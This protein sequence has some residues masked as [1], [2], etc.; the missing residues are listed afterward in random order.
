L[1][2]RLF[3][4]WNHAYLSS[5]LETL[6]QKHC[7]KDQW[8][9][10]HPCSKPRRGHSN[11]Q[12][13]G[14]SS[15][16]SNHNKASSLLNLRDVTVPSS[17][18]SSSSSSGGGG[19]QTSP[20]VNSAGSSSKH[21]N[22]SNGSGT[23]RSTPSSTSPPFS[24]ASPRLSL[25]GASVM[26]AVP[27]SGAS[28]SSVGS[29]GSNETPSRKWR[30]WPIG[31]SSSSSSVAPDTSCTSGSQSTT[32]II[33][34]N[35]PELNHV[36]MEEARSVI[37]TNNNNNNMEETYPNLDPFLSNILPIHDAENL[38][39]CPHPRSSNKSNSGD[40]GG[41]GGVGSN[42]SFDEKSMRSTSSAENVFRDGAEGND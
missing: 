10:P 9:Q 19:G 24:M 27:S 33:E 36:L 29:T 39:D 15:S 26:N 30:P 32:A 6:G 35:A 23:P 37:G 31:A 40:S 7:F 5:D 11:K 13:G 8:P 34:L 20:S 18:S 28:V 38:L 12:S 1:D 21:M 25:A 16:S 3:R 14:S 41:G 22:S 4:S 2:E 17:S 42:T